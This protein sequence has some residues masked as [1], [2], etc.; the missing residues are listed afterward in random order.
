MSRNT[1]RMTRLGG[2]MN[3]SNKCIKFSKSKMN[4][5]L[6][7]FFLKNSF[8][9]EPNSKSSRHPHLNLLRL[10][11]IQLRRWFDNMTTHKAETFK[12]HNFGNVGSLLKY[13][14]NWWSI[15][16]LVARWD[17]VDWFFSVRDNWPLLDHR[18]IPS[19]SRGSLQ[20]RLHHHTLSV[21]RF[22][23]A[24]VQSFGDQKKHPWP[25]RRN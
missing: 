11:N 13:E 16:S 14:I 2:K 25:E 6:T 20:Y 1:R 10:S 22:Q 15:E 12:R 19:D 23:T 5:N 3:R 17:G 21:P 4:F 9:M 7:S 8:L 24:N 18:E